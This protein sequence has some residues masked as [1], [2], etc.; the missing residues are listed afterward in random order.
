MESQKVICTRMIRKTKKLVL[1]HIRDHFNGKTFSMFVYWIT[2][3]IGKNKLLRRIERDWKEN[4]FYVN[5][6]RIKKKKISRTNI[7]MKEMGRWRR[8]NYEEDG[9]EEEEEEEKT[10]Q[11]YRW[12]LWSAHSKFIVRLAPPCCLSHPVI[13]LHS[14]PTQT[15]HL[16]ATTIFHT[17]PQHS[18]RQNIP[19][20]QRHFHPLHPCTSPPPFTTHTLRHH[21]FL[22][23]FI[24]WRC[25]NTVRIAW[26]FCRRYRA[27][28]FWNK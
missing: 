1:L 12:T 24:V 21:L 27:D 16:Y 10:Y 14:T 15:L 19:S 11:G 23:L 18:S 6:S 8:E 28:A 7:T 9:E 20:F 3:L 25:S 26:V 13:S 22:F 4:L 2:A 5:K 17:T